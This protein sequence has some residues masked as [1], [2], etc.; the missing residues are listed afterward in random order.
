MFTESWCLPVLPCICCAPSTVDSACLC[1]VSQ[2]LPIIENT[3]LILA[4]LTEPC[5]ESVLYAC[6]FIGN[7]YNMGA[8]G[9]AESALMDMMLDG[10]EVRN[11]RTNV[12]QQPKLR[13]YHTGRT[14]LLCN[15]CLSVTLHI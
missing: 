10:I 6:R 15:K 4:Q 7:K 13:V 12:Q 2:D 14:R 5:F 11:N 3:V 8:N 9:L 1:S